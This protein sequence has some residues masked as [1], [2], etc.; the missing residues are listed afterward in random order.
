MFEPLKTLKRGNFFYFSFL[1]SFWGVWGTFLKKSPMLIGLL[2]GGFGK[3]ISV[4]IEKVEE[5]GEGEEQG[6]KDRHK[7][8]PFGKSAGDIKNA[9][10][11]MVHRKSGEGKGEKPRRPA[12]G[13]R[14]AGIAQEEIDRKAC[15]QRRK[16][17]GHMGGGDAEPE[18][19][20]HAAEQAGEKT[21]D[22]ITDQGAAG[23]LFA[24]TVCHG[25][26]FP[27]LRYRSGR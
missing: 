2:S 21:A 18:I 15:G 1:K 16:G 10:D 24:L 14:Q 17:K 9:L 13:V 26:M 25:V 6:G 27:P 3:K 7:K 19:G 23:F 22:G 5:K 8:R 11:E 12:S 20:I 4:D